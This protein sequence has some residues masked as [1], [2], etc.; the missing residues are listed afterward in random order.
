MKINDVMYLCAKKKN[1]FMYFLNYY[2]LYTIDRCKKSCTIEKPS[3]K[4]KQT[5]KKKL[6]KR[7]QMIKRIS[8]GE[9]SD[10]ALLSLR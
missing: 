8:F 10:H 5:F 1:I 7:K 2:K 3:E 6:K 4:K 9:A